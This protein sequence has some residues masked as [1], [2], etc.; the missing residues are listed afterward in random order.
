MVFGAEVLADVMVFLLPLNL[1]TNTIGYLLFME[2]KQISWRRVLLTPMVI[3]Q[4]IGITIGLSGWTMPDLLQNTL[5]GLGGCMSPASMLLAGFMMGKF[6]LKHLLDGGRAYVL[7][8]VRLIGI[9]VIFGVILL[10]CGMK[11][12]YLMMP[13]L[14]AGMPLGLNLV[15][16][17]ESLGNEKMASENAKSCFV[18]YLLAVILL[19][20]TFAGVTYLMQ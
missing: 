16:Y 9:P 19:P 3:G 8:L 7:S 12:T 4:L 15:V 10:L 5:T 6:S 2:D 18:S 20:V 11:G 17:P 14:V 1:A 13:L